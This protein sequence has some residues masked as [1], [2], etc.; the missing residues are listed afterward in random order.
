MQVTY[1][2]E[3]LPYETTDPYTERVYDY[4]AHSYYNPISITLGELVDGGYVDWNDTKFAWDWYDETQRTRVQGMIERRFWFREIC[5][6]PPEVWRK[7]FIEALNEAMRTARLMYKA[8]DDATGPLQDSDEYHKARTI[9][10]DFPATLLN[11][12]SEDYASAGS[13]YEYE[14]IRQGDLLDKME[15]LQDYRDP[16][17]Y[18]LD[19]LERCFSSLVSTNIDGF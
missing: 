18:I 1:D 3:I 13:D 16:D 5:A 9:A 4:G 10:S 17:G 8:L 7:F 19:R 12:S 2:D 11:G 15:R 14:T 6:T